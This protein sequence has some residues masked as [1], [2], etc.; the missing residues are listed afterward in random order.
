MKFETF[1]YL[2]EKGWSLESFPELDS[3]QTLVL[4]FAARTYSDEPAP[5]EELVAAYPSSIIMGASTAGEI[6]EDELLDGSICVA[7]LRFEHTRL[8]L[9]EKKLLI[10]ESR[11][12]GEQVASGLLG[13]GLRGVFVLASGLAV[14]GSAALQGMTSVLPSSVSIGGGFSADGVAFQETWVLVGGKPTVDGMSGVGFYGDRVLLGNGSAGGY[15]TF[16][17]KYIVTGASGAVL[18]T[19][20]G[21]P[22]LE[23]FTKELGCDPGEIASRGLLY[24]LGLRSD[25]E[26]PHPLIRSVIGVDEASGS[27]LFGSDVPL[28]YHATFMRAEVES[29]IGGAEAAAAMTQKNIESAPDKGVAV[30]VSCIARRMVLAERTPDELGATLDALPIGMSQLGFYAYSEISP[31][32]PGRCDI[33]NQTMTVMTFAES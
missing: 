20:D 24:P 33:Q 25:P 32:A 29:I 10:S 16:G 5:L 22:A 15:E 13:D 23:I 19:L 1:Q 28:G 6:F 8:K 4:A 26:D 3:E 7:V 21:S 11:T 9:I 31:C 14:N 12:A 30:C 27:V 2:P 18:H 17:T